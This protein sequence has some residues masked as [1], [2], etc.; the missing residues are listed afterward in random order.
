MAIAQRMRQPVPPPLLILIGVVALVIGVAALMY[1][2]ISATSPAAVP[3]SQFLG[4]VEAGQVSHVTQ[5]GTTLEVSG[6]HGDYQVTLPTILTD[7]Y[8]DIEH[9]AREGGAA[10]PLF[11]AQ[12]APDTS[13]IGL[14]LAAVLP[15]ALLL[16]VIM[17]VLVVMRPAR[18]AG[19]RSL[20]N[21]LRELDDAYRAGLI[22]EDERARQRTRILDGT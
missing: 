17:L 2:W 21:R 10:V 4:N 9:A 5:V 13:W 3:Y 1:T 16:G 8:A 14:L 18:A 22:S 7:V 19:A 20:T 15:V 6:P 12:P 11:T